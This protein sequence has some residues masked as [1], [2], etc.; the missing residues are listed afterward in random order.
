MLCFPL[1]P[2]TSLITNLSGSFRN[3]HFLDTFT[4]THSEIQLPKTKGFWMDLGAGLEI[5]GILYAILYRGVHLCFYILVYSIPRFSVSPTKQTNNKKQRK[6][7]VNHPL[8]GTGTR[9]AR[10]TSYIFV[11]NSSNSAKL[12]QNPAPVP[13]CFTT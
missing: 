10:I 1:A 3:L 9:G 5:S 13:P 12:D 7:H 6:N 11:S 8:V 2:L 4:R